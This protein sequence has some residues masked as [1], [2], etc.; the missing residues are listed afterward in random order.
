MAPMASG[1]RASGATRSDAHGC[2]LPEDGHAGRDRR[3]ATMRLPGDSARARVIE[4]G[5]LERRAVRKLGLQPHQRADEL[6]LRYGRLDASRSPAAVGSPAATMRS[7]SGRRH[8]LTASP[9]RASSPATNSRRSRPARARRAPS[10]ASDDTRQDVGRAHELRDEQARW[11]G[12]RCPA[13]SPSCS[14]RPACITAMR[15]DT[16]SASSWSCVT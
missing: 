12:D 4:H 15:S 2:A 16:A 8:K 11:A 13:G 6:G 9:S 3:P 5:D 1:R 10:R 7:A 14:M